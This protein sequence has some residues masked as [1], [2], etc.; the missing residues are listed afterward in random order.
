MVDEA[1]M[2]QVY[3]GG[4]PTPLAGRRIQLVEY[5]PEWPRLYE[6]EAARIRS[7]LGERV[8][9]LEHVGS[10]SVPQLAA[11]PLIDM[12]LVVDNSADEPAY[13]PDMERA[14][15][16]L[17]IREADWFEHRLFK[18]PDTN[19]NVH[20][21]SDGCVEID[22]MLTFRDW[23]RSHPEDLSCYLR[24][25]RDLA[26]REWRYTQEY[27]DAKTEVVEQILARARAAKGT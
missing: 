27:A 11:K 24:T 10:T 6:H 17:H 22:R 16:K 2:R 19:V 21:F 14:G 1:R 9:L 8:L 23:L 20:V 12:L 7:A 25:K 13:V 5:D 4:G 3:V 18:G 26:Q 15:Y